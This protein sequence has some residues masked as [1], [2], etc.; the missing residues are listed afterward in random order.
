MGCIIEA[1]ERMK[2]FVDF[3]VNSTLDDCLSATPAQRD[4]IVG[5]VD[6]FL[7]KVN[8]DHQSGERREMMEAIAQAVESNASDTTA[9]DQMIDERAARRT[10]LAHDAVATGKTINALLTPDQRAQ[11]A[12]KIRNHHGGQHGGHGSGQ[13]SGPGSF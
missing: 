6:A 8:A 9:I 3:K 4:Q 10:A 7:D 11:L 5:I 13:G 2:K 1:P 12:D